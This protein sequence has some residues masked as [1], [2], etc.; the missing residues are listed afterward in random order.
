[1][2]EKTSGAD[3]EDGAALGVVRLLGFSSRLGAGFGFGILRT[4]L[5]LAPFCSLWGA[6][7]EADE[8]IASAW[9]VVRILM[10]LAATS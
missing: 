1:M 2:P 5:G 10:G 7:V 8:S 3:L 4:N 9:S 6:C